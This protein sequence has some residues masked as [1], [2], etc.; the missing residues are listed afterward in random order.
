VPDLFLCGDVMTGRGI[1][2][3]LDRPGD[4]VLREPYL[5]DAR[6]YVRLAEDA[7]G[8]V[9]LPVADKWPW[10]E[11]LDVLDRLNPDARIINLETAVT[12]H[13]EFS[14]GKDIHY[15]MNPANVG[16]L[17][18][19]K[20]DVCVLANN[21]VLDFGPSGL[22]ETLD[23]LAGAGLATAGAGRV[24]AS[25]WS[26]A[27]AGLAGG[28]RLVVLA[29]GMSSSG[30]PPGWAAG[31]ARPGVAYLPAGSR[32]ARAGLADRVRAARQ[33]HDGTL[34]VSLHIG[35]NWGYDV[36]A[37]E[38]ALAHT[39]IEAGADL[40]HGHSS[41]HPR[42][43]EVYRGK[44]ILYGCG[45]FID[46]YEGIGGHQRYR[47][48]LRPMWFA[49]L[50]SDGSLGRLRIVVM[51]ARQMRLRPAD[52]ADVSWL[53]GQLTRAG[54]PFGSAAEVSADGTITVRWR[55]A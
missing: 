4:P 55:A 48:D 41:H 52:A 24:E 34:V 32:A 1:D 38:V 12:S 17:T 3:I 44:L 15:R 8:P 10:G 7:N 33:E 2:Q 19:A 54:R 6:D 22:I 46:D 53:A 37:D 20:P 31:Q 40:V 30:I 5:R 21:H 16:C 18:C 26:P 13:G 45:D 35:P 29:A 36:A 43:V 27:A 42:P 9:G 51:Q 50:R 28:G 49:S 23:A 14:A 11:A 47:A 39:V 25:A